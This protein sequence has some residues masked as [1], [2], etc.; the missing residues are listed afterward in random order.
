MSDGKDDWDRLY[1]E[2]FQ[3]ESSGNRVW[4][5]MKGNFRDATTIPGLIPSTQP[6]GGHFEPGDRIAGRYTIKGIVGS[7][8]MGIVYRA[9]Q[10]LTN[11]TVALKVV[12]PA[13]ASGPLV[14]RFLEEIQ[15]LGRLD[16]PG[17]ARIYDADLHKDG[18]G[19]SIVFFT[20]DLVEGLPAT[21]LV[22]RKGSSQQDIIRLAVK[23]CEAVQYAHDHGVI[24]CDLKPGN[25]L[26]KRDGSPVVIDFGLARLAQ[27]GLKEGAADSSGGSE[28]WEGTPAYMSPEQFQG[29]VYETRGG[30]SIDIYS[31]AVVIFELLSGRKPYD[32]PDSPSIEDLRRTILFERPRRLAEC[33]ENCDPELDRTLAKA[34]RKDPADRYYSVASFQRALQRLLPGSVSLPEEVRWKPAAGRTIPSTRWVLDEKLGEGGCGEVWLAHHRELLDKRVVKFCDSEEKAAF[35]RRE[36]TLYKLL[37]EKIGRHEHFVPLEEV[38]LDEPPYYLMAEYI[39]ASNLECWFEEHGG[40]EGVPEPAR[41]EII[42]QAADALQAAHDVGVLHRDVKPSNLLIQGRPGDP[43]SLHVWVSDFGIGQVVSE[44][45]LSGHSSGFTRTLFDSQAT[46]GTQLYLAPEVAAGGDSTARSDIYSLGL[47]LFQLLVGDFRRPLTIDW[48]RSVAD[49]LLEEDLK[50][51]LAGNPSERFAGAS[52]LADHLRELPERR[53]QLRQAEAAMAARDRSARRRR[54]YSAAAMVLGAAAAVG[55][56]MWISSWRTTRTAWRDSMLK[57]IKAIGLSQSPHRSDTILRNIV[58]VDADYPPDLQDGFRDELIAALA[59]ASLPE[60][61]GDSSAVANGLLGRSDSGEWFAGPVSGSELPLWRMR[62]GSLQRAGTLTGASPDVRRVAV[63]DDGM[64]AAGA[65]EGDGV[66]VWDR[67]DGAPGSPI[68]IGGETQQFLTACHGPTGVVAVA[69]PSGAVELFFRSKDGF[70]KPVTLQREAPQARRDGDLISPASGIEALKP[71]FTQPA[72]ALSFSRDGKF[73]AVA[74]AESL[75]VFVWNLDTREFVTAPHT[76]GVNAIAWHP[77]KGAEQQASRENRYEFVTGGE[78]GTLKI[79][80]LAIP[81]VDTPGPVSLNAALEV[82]PIEEPIKSLSYDA[83]ANHLLAAAPARMLLC[84]AETLSVIERDESSV[85]ELTAAG[86]TPDGTLVLQHQDGT[87]RAAHPAHAGA[88]KSIQ[89]DR[90]I[91]EIG[92]EIETGLVGVT[93]R[94]GLFL[95]DLIGARVLRQYPRRQ[96]NGL[97]FTPRGRELL[98]NDSEDELLTAWAVPEAEGDVLRIPDKEGKRRGGGAGGELAVTPRDGEQW[99]KATSRGDKLRVYLCNEAED[100]DDKVLDTVELE[101]GAVRPARPPID[102]IALH[103]RAEWVAVCRSGQEQAELWPVPRKKEVNPP[104]KPAVPPTEKSHPPV[105]PALVKVDDGPCESMAWMPDGKRLAVR[106][107]RSITFFETGTWRKIGK[108]FDIG[109]P[110]GPRTVMAVTSDGKFLA[111][112]AESREIKLLRSVGESGTCVVAATLRP[113]RLQSLSALRF[114]GKGDRFLVAGTFDGQIQ[115]WDLVKLRQELGRQELDYDDMP[116]P[117]VAIECPIRTVEF[118]R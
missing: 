20:M 2:R 54:M 105:E 16:N 95:V 58:R 92:E 73:L 117:P 64:L 24:H 41:L 38:S 3:D 57:E 30:Q 99:Y 100:L 60:V 93:T 108:P 5:A 31:L 7:G 82:R 118:V 51:C 27:L 78:S 1:T 17:L 56:P 103:P 22:A 74:S 25:I 88:F 113:A 46:G 67:Q 29:G 79:W 76:H 106:S 40:L 96:A 70:T 18:S 101:G 107:K 59:M 114:C 50:L 36:L 65:M 63:S 55:I 19:Q 94:D 66:T 80:R 42:S 14:D 77:A 23:L 109:A 33:I 35:L 4:P 97:A 47:V 71:P 104:E 91:E 69:R 72:S 12:A 90:S 13:F 116:L 10:D 61:A 52:L 9:Q 75:N 112:Q 15:L 26:V 8:G 84:D 28:H 11:R 39:A 34:M 32:F 86:F 98:I 85:R 49:P 44:D 102:S 6:A 81:P 45:V 62:D 115:I 21:E 110:V 53:E 43:S 87:A 111:T 83:G 48:R 68:R 89:L 37:K